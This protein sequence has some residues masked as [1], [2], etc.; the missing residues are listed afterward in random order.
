LDQFAADHREQAMASANPSTVRL[1]Y[2]AVSILLATVAALVAAILARA[3]GSTVAGSALT[4]G[5]AFAGA[6]VLAITVFSSL[7][8]L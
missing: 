6:L 5:S 3:N 8:I 1:L 4:G 7:E 2:V